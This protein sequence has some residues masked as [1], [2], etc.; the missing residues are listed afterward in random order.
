MRILTLLLACLSAAFASAGTAS[1]Q[2]MLRPGVNVSGSLG[3]NS[4]RFG[5]GVRYD[6]YILATTPGSRWVIDMQGEFDTQLWLAIGQDCA[7][8]TT[9]NWI[10]SDDDGGGFLSTDARMVFKAGGGSYLIG[11][12]GYDGQNAAGRYVLTARQ[13][14]GQ[15]RSG[16]MRPGLDIIYVD[17]SPQTA[18][19]V[20]GE[21]SSQAAGTTFRDCELC[22]S[23]EAVWGEGST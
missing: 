7:S 3:P 21:P 14:P 22:P 16:M 2:N 1:A 19:T 6:C 10:R 5:S 4:P 15:H 11:A 13:E 20:G 12:R 17:P 18:S 23:M 8:V 9:E